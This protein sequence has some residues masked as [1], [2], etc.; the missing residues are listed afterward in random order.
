MLTESYRKALVFAA[1]LHHGH[2]RLVD[3]IRGHG[4]AS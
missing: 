1:T 3:R 4:A 2:L